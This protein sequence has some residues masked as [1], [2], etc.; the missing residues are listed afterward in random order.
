MR[1]FL[2]GSRGQL[3]RALAARLSDAEI[4]PCDQP[5]CD[6]TQA[7]P[8]R[9]AILAARP[10]MVLH[11]AAMTDVDGCARDPDL[12]YRVNGLGTQNVAL[13][14]AEIGAALLYVST[15]EVFDGAARSPYSEFDAPNPV[16]AYGRSKLAGEW[17]TLHLVPRFYVVRTSWLYAS[18]GANFIHKILERAAAGQRL[19]VVADEVATPT[20]A[21]DL[22]EAVARLIETGQHGIYHLA[23]AGHCSRYDWAC[24]ALELAGYDV[25]VEPITRA[26]YPRPSTPPAFT[27]LANQA[28]AAL[29]IT[30]RPWQAALEEFMQGVEG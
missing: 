4:A 2:T 30:L 20:L 8:I 25:P 17:Y 26:D 10:E 1:I 23:N 9:Q 11:C 29:G 14:C 24:K 16:N 15:N 5:E 28:A 13:A 19:R 27:A 7:G 6:V 3:G 21:S 22:A 12:A 18:N